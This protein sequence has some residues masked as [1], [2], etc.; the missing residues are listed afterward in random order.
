MNKFFTWAFVPEARIPAAFI[1]G[2]IAGLG[3]A[4]FFAVIISFVK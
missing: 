1:C 3:A 4:L 2:S